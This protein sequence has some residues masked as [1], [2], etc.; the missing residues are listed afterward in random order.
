MD[1]MDTFVSHHHEN[2][3]SKWKRTKPELSPC[4]LFRV[5]PAGPG[6]IGLAMIRRCESSV[7]R[8][9]TLRVLT[10]FAETGHLEGTSHPESPRT[11][12]EVHE[13]SREPLLYPH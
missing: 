13:N 2:R 10:M 3:Y 5:A 4:S 11:I 1:S 9:D 8:R 7:F 12:C 6:A